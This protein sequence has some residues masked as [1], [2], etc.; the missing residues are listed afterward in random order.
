MDCNKIEKML[1]AYIDKELD[2]ATEIKVRN[3]L[4]DCNVC[5]N[6]F[7]IYKEI[8][9]AIGSVE[10]IEPSEEFSQKIC[11][12]FHED[13]LASMPS[14]RYM[15]S[16]VFN[17]FGNKKLFLLAA[18]VFAFVFILAFSLT[19]N[20]LY[21]FSN[22]DKPDFDAVSERI[23]ADSL[24]REVAPDEQDKS[25]DNNDEYFAFTNSLEFVGNR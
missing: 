22:L 10:E 23:V 4:M 20:R 13:N 2:P 21:E 18:C 8:K 7:L 17:L 16:F 9:D 1:N 24:S 15:D 19:G 11:M 14:C 6:D 12:M 3:H 25:Y 5:Y